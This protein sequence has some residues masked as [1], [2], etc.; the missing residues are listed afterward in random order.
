MFCITGAKIT[1]TGDDPN[2]GVFFVPIDAPDQAV[3][4]GR[5][6]E[7][8]GSMITGIIPEVAHKINRIEIRTRY[9][10]SSTIMLKAPRAITSSFILTDT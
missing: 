7:N 4:V 3:K 2:C 9:S 10:G 8:T 5:I 1:V 6:G